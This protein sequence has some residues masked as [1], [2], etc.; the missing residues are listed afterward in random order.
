LPKEVKITSYSF[1][2]IGVQWFST[3]INNH[4]KLKV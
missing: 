2:L 3:K 4:L 1:G